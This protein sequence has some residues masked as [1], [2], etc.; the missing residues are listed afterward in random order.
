[1]LALT[2]LQQL[3]I[4][5]AGLLGGVLDV[6]SEVA[7]TVISRVVRGRHPGDLGKSGEEEDL[8]KS[9]GGDGADSV[10]TGGHIG[11]LKVLARA[12]V[13][14]EGDVR[15]AEESVHLL[16]QAEM[17]WNDDALCADPVTGKTANEACCVCGGGST[18]ANNYAPSSEEDGITPSLDGCIRWRQQELGTD[19]TRCYLDYVEFLS[20]C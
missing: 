16:L 13:S 8:E 1:M 6:L 10:N 18:T 7:N 12:Q 2:M 14:I 15:G 4:E 9:S 19:A 3:N 11:E 5:L 20:N 17:G